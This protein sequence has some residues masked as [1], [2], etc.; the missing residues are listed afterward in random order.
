MYHY[1][2][3]LLCSLIVCMH[4]WRP[5]PL[6]RYVPILLSFHVS[7]CYVKIYVYNGSLPHNNIHGQLRKIYCTW[8]NTESH[9]RLAMSLNDILQVDSSQVA[10]TN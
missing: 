7:L 8:L 3:I 6:S 1:T 9:R 10:E 5:L 4:F 2:V